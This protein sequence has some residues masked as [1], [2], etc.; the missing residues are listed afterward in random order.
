MK[1]NGKMKTTGY[2]CIGFAALITCLVIFGVAPEI[3]A[4]KELISTWLIA[5]ISLL[6]VNAGKRI[7]G[8]IAMAKQAE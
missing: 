1:T 3:T 7:V 4:A 5:G 2:I 8:G 6:G